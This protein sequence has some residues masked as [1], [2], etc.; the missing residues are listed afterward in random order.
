M[1]GRGIQVGAISAEESRYDSRRWW[2]SRE[3]RR[4]IT[5]HS[6]MALL[7]SVGTAPSAAGFGVSLG[8]GVCGEGDTEAERTVG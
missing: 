7:L 2:L 3:G 5:E 4:K 6:G 8:P 1:L